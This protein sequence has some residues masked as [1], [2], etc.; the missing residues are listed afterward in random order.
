MLS[1]E[2]IYQSKKSKARVGRIHTPHGVID[3]PGFV[4]V[5]TNGSLQGVDNKMLTDAFSGLMFC[6]TYHLALHPGAD[7]VEAAGGLHS[8]IGRDKPL[9]TDSGG[10][11]VFSLAY[12]S[13]A[14]ELKSQ[15]RK[16][17]SNA[18]IKI[19]EEGVIFR[20]YRD[21]SLIKFTPESSVEIQKKLG[22]DIII[23]FDELPPFHIAQKDLAH[24][25]DR[26][27]RWQ[28]RSLDTH[29]A[30][31]CNQSMYAVVHGGLESSLRK[32]SALFLR[33]LPFDGFAVG[34]SL[35][36][37]TEDIARVLSYT[38]PHL[39]LD[40]PRHLLGIADVPGITHGVK[41]GMDTFDSCYP[42][43]LARHGVLLTKSGRLKITSGAYKKDFTAIEEDCPCYSCKHYSRAYLHHLFKAH[44]PCALQ[45]ASI[46]N[47]V[48]MD[49]MMQQI[50]LDIT[51]DLI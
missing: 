35:G 9:I 24:A 41:Y 12:G 38:V 7:V 6:N 40:K 39:P 21:G 33:D 37:V 20:S 46:H 51:Q 3:T 2:I 14:S 23:P 45:L 27:H 4:P 5:A 17:Q 49:R 31:P 32:Q 18:V 10:F 44:E 22:A 16:N 19:N 43:R 8:F 25:L 42:M 34:G 13:V 30:R 1:F 11:Q 47:V 36:K 50:R 28:K 48:C 26:T 29:L 15:G